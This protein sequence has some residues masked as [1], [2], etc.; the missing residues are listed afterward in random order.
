MRP[1]E[2]LRLV[3][4][5]VAFDLLDDHLRARERL[6]GLDIFRRVLGIT[7]DVLGN[8]SLQPALHVRP[9]FE[10]SD[11]VA[12]DALEIV[13]EPTGREQ[14]GQARREVRVGRRVW[15]FIRGRF[16]Q[17]LGANESSKVGVLLVDERHE[18]VLRQLGF[19]PVADGDLGRTFHVYAAVV[20][21]TRQLLV[22]AE[23]SHN[24]NNIIV[25]C[26]TIFK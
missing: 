22:T 17:R 26:F 2:K 5:G 11:L 18:A 9:L 20:G 6:T 10:G 1:K 14:V 3:I 13:R 15:I 4:S 7:I 8:P 19:A 23:F 21:Q 12:D 24:D 16:L 25:T